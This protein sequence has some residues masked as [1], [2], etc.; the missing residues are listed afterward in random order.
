M[1]IMDLSPYDDNQSQ[2]HSLTDSQEETQNT[3]NHGAESGTIAHD[4]LASRFE[5][6]SGDSNHKEEE[7]NET[8][9]TSKEM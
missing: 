1:I 6:E 3:T 7:P 2:F 5:A 9:W 4:W 8:R